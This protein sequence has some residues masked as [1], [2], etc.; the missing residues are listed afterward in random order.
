MLSFI[1]KNVI[2]QFAFEITK[3]NIF[4]LLFSILNCGVLF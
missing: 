4:Q 3:I 1:Y 2:I